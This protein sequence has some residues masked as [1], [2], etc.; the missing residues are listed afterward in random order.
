VTRTFIYFGTVVTGQLTSLLLLPLVTK[1]LSPAAYGQY[2]LALATTGLIG[3]LG[4]VWIRN[5]AM[6]LFFDY[7]KVGRTRAFFWTVAALQATVMLLWLA[8]SYVIV[9]ATFDALPL[10]LYAAAGLSVL[11]AD[12]YALSLNTLRAG[13]RAV[14]F[15]IAEIL[16]SV[17]RLGG[18]WL[19]L[20]AGWRTPTMLFVFA[21]LSVAAAAVAAAPGLR[22]VLAGP[23]GFERTA[24]AELV[25]LGLPSIPLSI[26]GWIIALS[27]R[28][29][30]AWFI[31]LQAVGVY[32]AAYGLA[33]RA[34]GGLTSA[35]FMTA[36]PGILTAWLED[37]HA[38]SRT[39]S[40]YLAAFVLLSTGPCVLLVLQHEFVLTLLTTREYASAAA[41]VP[42]VVAGGWLAGVSTYLNRPLELTKRCYGTLS[43]IT[44]VTAGIN[45]G[46]NIWLIPQYGVRAAAFSTMC[47]FAALALLS[48]VFGRRVFRV[49]IPWSA[50]TARWARPRRWRCFPMSGGDGSFACPTRGAPCS[51]PA[52]RPPPPGWF[53]TGSLTL[54][55]RSRCSS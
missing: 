5:V 9:R 36:W 17:V 32:S 34:V 37:Q 25:W 40:R 21:T 50:V 28:T 18:T 2:A 26:G 7:V 52:P 41:V 44:I 16:A 11:A 23:L 30:L 24:V 20:L 42:Y 33:D 15:G 27:D 31:D 55:H 49:P 43:A 13:Q 1:F 53:R 14:S 39:I 51:S 22:R 38:A 47:A 6:R 4:S 8:G 46:L 12:F 3:S 35:L 10:T 29:L 19:A 48:Y 45:L 54:W